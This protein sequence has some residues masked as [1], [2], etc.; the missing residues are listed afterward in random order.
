[1]MEVPKTMR[2]A[3]YRGVNDVRVETI[4]VPEIGPGEVLVKIHTC[5]ICGTDLKKIHT[6][7]HSAP[8]VFGHEMAGT[9]AAVGGGVTDFAIGD[10]VMAY[11][12]IPCGECYYCRKQTFA[13]CETYKKVGCTAAFMPSGGGFAEYIRVMDW[14]VRK[15]LVKIPDGVPFEQAAFIEPV[16]TCYKAVEMLALEPDETVLVIGQGPIGILLAA[17]AKRTGATVLTSDLYGERHAVAAKFGLDRPLDA[18]GD[19]VA[20]AKAAT[21]G[22]GTDVA[23]VAVGGNA[24]ITLAM[25]AIRPGGRVMLFAATQHG[26][27][28]FDPA[29]VCM[30]E[31]TLMGSY[32][33]S[34]AIND[35]V[36][37]LVL[38]GYGM[39]F[40][41]TQLISHRFSIEDA[42]A[43][44]DLASNPQPDSMKIVI[45]PEL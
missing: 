30:D 24:L 17:L 34:V 41:L 3:V 15:G 9:I 45:Q 13:Q 29:A 44:I 37:Q 5:G 19:V 7:S 32:S 14:I 43:A 42:V 2:A 21:D 1:M 12:H 25:N 23:L 20:A 22:R 4:P 26:E 8:R 27:A 16:N 6:G 36:A 35:E 28:P 31:K 11:H 39:G 38:N 33:S 10:R 40:D 18:R